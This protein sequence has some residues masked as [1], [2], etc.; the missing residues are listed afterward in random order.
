QSMSAAMTS[1]RPG[2]ASPVQ[3]TQQSN[4][5]PMSQNSPQVTE[6]ER[7]LLTIGN[8][9]RELN[10]QVRNVVENAIAL[11]RNLEE[12]KKLV[13]Y[14]QW[15]PWVKENLPFT[16][17]TARRYMDLYLKSKSQLIT[18]AKTI[19]EAMGIITNPEA[20]VEDQSKETKKSAIAIF[21]NYLKTKKVDEGEKSILVEFLK[22]KEES[23]KKQAKEFGMLLKELQ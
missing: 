9:F 18:D 16:S 8:L 1:R 13:P 10:K 11:G 17:R 5:I 14:G 23:A 7:K 2:G 21:K 4:V 19:N 6:L 15:E 12:V 3:S 22:R 20:E